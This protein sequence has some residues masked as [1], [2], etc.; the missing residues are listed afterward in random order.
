MRLFKRLK[1][2]GFPSNAIT[3]EQMKE[4]LYYTLVHF[5][6]EDFHLVLDEKEQFI[7]VW[8][9]N[10]YYPIPFEVM[11][12]FENKN[13]ARSFVNYVKLQLR[14]AGVE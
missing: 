12:L 1:R 5:V 8:I 2:G 11:V 14:K 9:D 6:T 7:N 3:L 4:L 13:G 10:D